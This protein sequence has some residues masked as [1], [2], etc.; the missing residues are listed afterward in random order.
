MWLSLVERCVRDAEVVGSN[1]AIPTIWNRAA[2][3]VTGLPLLL[4]GV[5]M[6]E[7]FFMVF[8]YGL[9]HQLPERTLFSGGFQLPVCARDTGIYIGFVASLLVITALARRRR[10]TELP[11]LAVLLIGTAF[12][13]TM[14]VDG[15]SSYAGWRQTTNDLRLISGLLAGYA[16]PLV[17]IPMVNAQLWKDGT[18][19]R[20]LADVREAVMWLLSVPLVFVAARWVMPITGAAYPLLVVVA[21]LATFVTVNLVFVCLV[22]RWE[23]QTERLSDAWP[24]LA[25]ALVLTVAELAAAGGLRWFL[26]RLV[27]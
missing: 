5:M 8:G 1:P 7:R 25:L 4:P 3:P 17:A 2:G 20:P 21:V 9:C 10:P 18:P 6:L 26:E 27:A 11:N 14:V 12:V 23:R 24:Q 22:P 16:L 19:S 13:A 15:V